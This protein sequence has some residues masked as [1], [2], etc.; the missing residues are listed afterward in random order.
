MPKSRRE[1][2]Y[3]ELQRRRF[4]TPARLTVDWETASRCPTCDVPMATERGPFSLQNNLTAKGYYLKC[5]NSR[6]RQFDLPPFFIEV[7]A[8]G[9]V[10]VRMPGPKEYDIQQLTTEQQEQ[11]DEY[12]RQLYQITLD[13]REVRRE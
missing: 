10:P 12:H 11:L 4:E 13:K 5:R 6:C 7:L 8:N 2:E 1:R 9:T 3:E